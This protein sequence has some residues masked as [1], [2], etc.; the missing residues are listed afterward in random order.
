[1]ISVPR[2]IV[3]LSVLAQPALLR[4]VGPLA[5]RERYGEACPSYQDYAAVSQ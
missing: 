2:A 4:P 5:N 3:L 1:M